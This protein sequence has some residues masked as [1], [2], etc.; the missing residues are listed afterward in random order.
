MSSKVSKFVFTQ[1]PF[2]LVKLL[3]AGAKTMMVLL[4]PKKKKK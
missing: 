2:K 3:Q 4:S 1:V